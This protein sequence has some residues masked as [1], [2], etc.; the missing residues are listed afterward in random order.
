MRTAEEMYNYC[1]ENDY[2]QGLTKGW[3]LKHFSLVEKSL[4]DDEEVVMAFIGLHNYISTTKHD[5][6]Y[7][8]AITNKRVIIGQKKLIGESIKLVMRKHLNDINLNSGMVFG[9]ITFDTIKETFNVAVAKKH[10]TPIFERLHKIFFSEEDPTAAPTAAPVDKM[11]KLKELKE[12]LDGGILTQEEFD[13]EKAK[14]LL[15]S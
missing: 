8:Y 14:I 6:N 9:V 10:S 5:S 11:S 7:A 12:L 13:S 3:A 1:L 15:K 4:M 2:G